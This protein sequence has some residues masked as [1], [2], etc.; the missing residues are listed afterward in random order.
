[1][2]RSRIGTQ[3]FSRRNVLGLA[4]AGAAGLGLAACGGNSG[5][6]TGGSGDGGNLSQWYHQYGE[7]GTQEAVKKYAD[8]YEDATVNVNWVMGDYAAKLSTSLLSGK[9][10][11]VFENNNV[12]IDEQKQGRYAELTSIVDPIKDT[13]NE[14]ALKAVTIEDKIWALPFLVDPQMFF[15]RKSLLDKAG[16]KPPETMDD[17]VDAAKEL[18]TSDQKGLF[19]GNDYDATTWTMIWA[20]GG[21]PM[22]EDADAVAYNTPGMVEGLTA[23]QQM[24]KDG[25]LLSGAPSNWDD[26]SAFAQGLSAITWGGCWALPELEDKF[27]DDLGIFAHPAV[28]KDGKQVSLVGLWS[29]QVAGASESVDEAIDFTKWLWIDQTE[30]QEDFALNYGFHIPA[31]TSVADEADALKDGLGKEMADM[32]KEIGVSRPAEWTGDISTPYDD[33]ISNV[34]KKGAD[35]ATELDKAEKASNKKVE[36]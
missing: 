2:S 28:G 6:L 33:G 32:A 4:G 29:E 7:K 17:L 5:G 34:L 36:Q 23:I 30:Y 16:I 27:G 31:V 24:K 10:V 25:S 22:N 9:D 1:M 21:S 26:P 19:L 8:A 15:Y 12:A 3:K 35:P 13:L 18:T 20:A 14:A 11:D